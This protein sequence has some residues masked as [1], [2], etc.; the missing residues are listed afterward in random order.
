MT[1]LEAGL[2][3]PAAQLGCSDRHDRNPL[4]NQPR[5][6]LGPPCRISVLPRRD[7]LRRYY[8][9]R[10]FALRHALHEPRQLWIRLQR[11]QQIILRDH[12]DQSYLSEFG[13][14]AN[15]SP[16]VPTRG[17][18]HCAG[19]V[20]SPRRDWDAR[21]V[22]VQDVSLRS[23]PLAGKPGTGFLAGGARRGVLCCRQVPP[24][25]RPGAGGSEGCRYGAL[26]DECFTDPVERGLVAS[27]GQPGGSFTGPTRTTSADI[28]GKRLEL[29]KGTLPPVPRP[30]CGLRQSVCFLVPMKPNGLPRSP[31]NGDERTPEGKLS[32]TPSHPTRRTI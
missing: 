16:E 27:F 28:E 20:L 22:T 13:G 7:G 14:P 15:N 6:H 17:R 10:E 26:R 32:P 2:L 24:G 8:D 29:L 1:E 21:S 19:P 12:R 31:G 9:P 23:L 11:F 30:D 5:R 4:G 3:T 18:P 25:G